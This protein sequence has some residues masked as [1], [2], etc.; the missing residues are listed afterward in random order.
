MAKL[1]PESTE[2]TV[3]FFKSQLPPLE[4]G[5]FIAKGFCGCDFGNP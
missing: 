4:W 5:S 2:I 3:E 1:K